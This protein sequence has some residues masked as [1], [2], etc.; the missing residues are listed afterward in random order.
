MFD[1]KKKEDMAA[2]KVEETSKGK[3][4]LITFFFAVIFNSIPFALLGLALVLAGSIGMLEI[5]IA[6]IFWHDDDK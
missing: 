4:A 1:L 6:D 5:T 3:W 2:A